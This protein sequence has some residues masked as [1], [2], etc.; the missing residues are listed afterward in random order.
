MVDDQR[1]GAHIQYVQRGTQTG[2]LSQEEGSNSQA[3]AQ[4]FSRLCLMLGMK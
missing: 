4:E 3:H 2:I 1:N